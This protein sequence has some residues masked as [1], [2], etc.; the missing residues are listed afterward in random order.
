MA[1]HIRQDKFGIATKIDTTQLLPT[2]RM[3]SGFQEWSSQRNKAVV[4]RQRL[5]H[6]AAASIKTAFL[7]SEHL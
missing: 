6:T 4:R 7:R 2:S 1:L 3:V 5:T